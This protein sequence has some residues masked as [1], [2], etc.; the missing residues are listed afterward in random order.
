ML[1]GCGGGEVSPFY[2]GQRSGSSRQPAPGRASL[3]GSGH[4]G[5]GN[6]RPVNGPSR[7][8]MPLLGEMLITWPT[9][10]SAPLASPELSPL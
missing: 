6:G 5:M 1:T 10:L 8:G 7:A 2:A 3:A 4:H 9:W